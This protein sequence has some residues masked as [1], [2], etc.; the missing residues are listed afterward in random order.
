M[1]TLPEMTPCCDVHDM[2]YDSCGNSKKQCDK[3]FEE[4]LLGV[5]TNPSSGT[6][7]DCEGMA[8]ILSAGV[9]MF[10]CNAYQM[11][12]KKACHCEKHEEL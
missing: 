9:G 4:C 11:S 2:C 1:Q 7:D 6:K 8:N 10:G 3:D 5:C 12:Q